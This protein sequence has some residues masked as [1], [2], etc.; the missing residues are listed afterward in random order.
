MMHSF[1]TTLVKVLLIQTEN[2]LLD[3]RSF[4]TTLVKV[5]YIQYRRPFFNTLRFNT[6]LVKV[7]YAAYDLPGLLL[8]VSI[9]LLLRF[10]AYVAGLQQKYNAF[11]YNSC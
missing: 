4:N 5:L 7:L 2:I 11:Q 10:Y 6:T 9:Q 8:V 3:E 1:N